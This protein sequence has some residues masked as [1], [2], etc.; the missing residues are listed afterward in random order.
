MG[1]VEAQRLDN[2][3]GPLLEG[4]CQRCEG[5][6]REQLSG[7]PQA[8]H[9]RGALAQLRLRDVGAAAVFFQHGRHD[10]IL[11]VIRKQRDDVV[12]NL[13]HDM[14]RAGAGVQ[15]QIVSAQLILMYHKPS[16]CTRAGS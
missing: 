10:F 7:V 9:I 13:I 14:N 4:L 2:V 3:P 5:I 11:R 12:G 1:D 6:R 15:H 16:M 8:P